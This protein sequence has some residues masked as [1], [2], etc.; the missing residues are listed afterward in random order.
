MPSV[1]ATIIHWGAFCKTEHILFLIICSILSLNYT[2]CF[3]LAI[4]H[5]SISAPSNLIWLPRWLKASLHWL[6]LGWIKRSKMVAND[7]FIFEFDIT[8]FSEHP[9]VILRLLNLFLKFVKLRISCFKHFLPLCNSL[10]QLLRFSFL[11][12]ND[13]SEFGDLAPKLFHLIIV[14]SL[15]V[16]ESIFLF[17]QLKS[18]FSDCLLLL[19]NL[20][21]QLFSMVFFII[22]ILEDFI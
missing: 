10:C 3:Y 9:H 15:E 11:S 22:N 14:I 21:R 2:R 1:F 8:F 12:F 19:D 5:A 7:L 20:L 13:I 4:R 16:W 18:L 17:L 6:L